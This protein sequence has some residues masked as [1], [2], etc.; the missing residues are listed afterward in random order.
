HIDRMNIEKQVF[1][2]ILDIDLTPKTLLSVGAEYQDFTN[3]GAPRGGLPLFY[4]DGRETD[5]SRSTNGGSRWS[6]F[7]HQTTRLFAAL[8][9]HFDSGWSVKLDGEAS[10][11]DYDEVIGYLYSNTGFDAATG[12]G[13]DMLSSRWAGDLEQHLVNLMV[14][15]PFTLFD[16]EHE[17][18]LGGS[19]STAEDEGDDYPGWWGG[20]DYWAPIPNAYDYLASGDWPK[21][22]LGAVGSQYGGRVE[23]TGA[24]AALRLKPVDSVSVILGGRVSD[25]EETQWNRSAAGTR[26]AATL[27][28]ETGVVT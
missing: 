26:T 3:S 12:A 10:R 25:W 2:G 5:F 16:R 9:H 27:T 22:Y 8:E 14:S 7:N 11:P 24:Y 18:M 23:Q 20:P 21:P 6:D 13:A 1:Y 19:Y 15:G 28:K 4:T 17:V